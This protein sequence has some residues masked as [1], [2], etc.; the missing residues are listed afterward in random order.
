MTVPGL[1][2]AGAPRRSPVAEALRLETLLVAPRTMNTGTR[3][4]GSTGTTR[5]GSVTSTTSR[6]KNGTTTAF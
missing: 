5:P 3:Y 2:D 6:P 1:E 4:G